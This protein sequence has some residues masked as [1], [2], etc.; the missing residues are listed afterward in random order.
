MMGL[1]VVARLAA[2]H[3]VE[4]ELRP[5]ADRGTV[6]DVLL[7]PSVL[8]STSTA[9]RGAPPVAGAERVA[10]NP[11]EPPRPAARSPFGAPLALESGRRPPNVRRPA[12]A[13]RVA[14]PAVRPNGYGGSAEFGGFAAAAERFGTNRP[15]LL[16][17][18]VSSRA[19]PSWSDLT[20]A[21]SA[22]AHRAGGT[23]APQP[24]RRARPQ[25]PRRREWQR[26]F[27]PVGLSRRADLA[28]APACLARG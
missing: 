2:R 17:P 22:G 13:P 16:G 14:T 6:A 24:Q 4:V 12:L 15:T 25:R 21:V 3:G 26:T 9:F 28:A 27:R 20:G 8:I 11:S 10:L 5:A 7:P 19:L 23:T 1:V 18:G